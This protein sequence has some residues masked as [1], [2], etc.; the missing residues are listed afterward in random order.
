M[1]YDGLGV[2]NIG[3]PPLEMERRSTFVK[4]V[5]LILAHLSPVLTS[6]HIT[7]ENTNTRFC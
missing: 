6:D 3:G 4:E 5:M 1:G 2:F 7:L